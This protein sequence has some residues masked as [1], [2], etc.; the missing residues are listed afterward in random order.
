MR[1]KLHTFDVRGGVGKQ[2]RIGDRSVVCKNT[3]PSII[4]L[5]LPTLV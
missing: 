1:E 2:S 3:D 4:L 5:G